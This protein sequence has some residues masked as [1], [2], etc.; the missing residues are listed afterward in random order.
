MNLSKDQREHL[1]QL[2]R[3]IR[4]RREQSDLQDGDAADPYVYTAAGRLCLDCERPL[5]EGD[6][7]WCGICYASN[8]DAWAEQRAE[9]RQRREDFEDLH[10]GQ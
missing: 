6:D 7:T 9:E 3:E 1:R 8:R 5:A 2:E 10:G 4:C